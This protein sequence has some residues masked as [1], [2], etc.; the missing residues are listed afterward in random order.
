M[1]LELVESSISRWI[2]GLRL[3]ARVCLNVAIEQRL[4]C[5]YLRRLY[6]PLL[7]FF[8]P[9]HRPSL[10][11]SSLISLIKDILCSPPAIALQQQ[12]S[13]SARTRTH[14]LLRG[15]RRAA[16]NGQAE[17]D[18]ITDGQ[19]YT[20]RAADVKC[21]PTQTQFFIYFLDACTYSTHTSAH[22]HR[23]VHKLSD[24]KYSANKQEWASLTNW[25][26]LMNWLVCVLWLTTLGVMSR[27]PLK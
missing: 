13:Q 2:I 6:P 18:R 25:R 3:W 14:R 22:T 11:S 16:G 8:S 4:G 23:R 26:A 10:P 5:V 12:I 24:L 27:L 17:A 21:A 15:R 9:S 1:G 20:Q 7:S 19:W